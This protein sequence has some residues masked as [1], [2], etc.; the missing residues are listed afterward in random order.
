MLSRAFTMPFES[1]APLIAVGGLMGSGKTSLCSYLGA[2]LGLQP[3]LD[4]VDQSYLQDLFH[5]R[6]RWAFEAQ[7]AFFARK[8]MTVM[9]ERRLGHAIILDRSL[10]EDRDVF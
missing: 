10:H 9:R 6:P 2:V 8:A 5:D 3:V 4:Q 1:I 7:L